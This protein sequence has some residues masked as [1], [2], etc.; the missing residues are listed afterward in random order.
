VI[1]GLLLAVA[2]GFCWGIFLAPVRILKA[3]A[4]ENIWIVWS[5]FAALVG[6]WAIAFWTVPHLVAVNREVGLQILLLT[7]VIGAV[8]GMAGFLYSY[9]VPVLGLGLATSLNAGASMAMSL[10]PLGVLHRD[11]ILHRSGA[12]TILGVVL[13]IAGTCFCGAGGRRREKELGKNPVQPNKINRT[14]LRCVVFTLAS[15]AIGTGMNIA[16]AFPNPIFAVAHKYGS[17]QFG[18]ANA[19]LA[20]Y[21]LGACFSNLV[22]AGRLVRKNTTFSRFY[23]TGWFRCLVWSLLMA[24]FFL[25]GEYSYA[26]AVSLLGSFGAVITWGVSVATMILTS[27]LWDVSQGEWQGRAA[28]EMALGVSVLM[29]AVVTLGFAQYFHTA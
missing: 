27:S 12:F 15:G 22:Y 17:S 3:W 25:I 5:I 28:Q 19:F 21:L 11:T 8:S 7:A 2:C 4:W 14:F 20:P 13:A 24:V 26:G 29:V 9:S 18:A 23:A 10:L 6:P 1:S 16:L